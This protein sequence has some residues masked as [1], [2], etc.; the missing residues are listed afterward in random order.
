MTEDITAMERRRFAR[1]T[2]RD[3][4]SERRVSMSVRVRDISL[5]GVLMLASRPLEEGQY[6]H[7]STRFGAQPLEA[8][9]EVRRVSTTRDDRGAYRI[10]ARFVGLDEAARRTMRQFLRNGSI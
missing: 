4:N 3:L 8:D 10:A 1:V 9:I 7:L 2:V 6:G 5:S